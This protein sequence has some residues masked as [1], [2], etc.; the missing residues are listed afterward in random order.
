M[1]V[2]LAPVDALWPKSRG[3]KIAIL[4]NFAFQPKIVDFTRCSFGA[5]L[6]L[7]TRFKHLFRAFQ[8]RSTLEHLFGEN[9]RNF[10]FFEFLRFLKVLTH[11]KWTVWENR[12][13]LIFA[14]NAPFELKIFSAFGIGPNKL[15]INFEPIRCNSILNSF[16]IPPKMGLKRGY[17]AKFESEGPR[18]IVRLWVRKIRHFGDWLKIVVLGQFF[19]NSTKTT[20]R[21]RFERV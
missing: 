10:S 4:T 20:L 17:L 11:P 16:E 9:L 18:P 6:G 19:L 7:Q 3:A 1:C 12:L 2:F 14:K 21:A 8:G 5:V 15:H 13:E